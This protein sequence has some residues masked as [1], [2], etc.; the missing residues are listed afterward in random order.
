M[1]RHKPTAAELGKLAK[2]SQSTVSLVLTGKWKGR[3]SKATADRVLTVAQKIGYRPNPAAQSLRLGGSKTILFL[4]PVLSNP[5]FARVYG[6]IAEVAKDNNLTIL[7]YPMQTADDGY[8][9][10]R[11]IMDVDAIIACSLDSQNIQP[12]GNLIPTVFIDCNPQSAQYTVNADIY[13]GTTK[14]IKKLTNSGF[15]IIYHFACIHSKWT[16][17]QRMTA[18][19]N[20]CTDNIELHRLSMIPSVE[21]AYRNAEW[22]L[23]KTTDKIGFFCDNDIIAEGV[24]LAAFSLNKSIPSEVSIIGMDDKP[25]NH[26]SSKG[27]S[28]VKIDAEMLGTIAMQ[29]LLE[30][31]EG[32]TPKSVIIPTQLV[33]RSTTV[34][35]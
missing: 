17:N 21:E 11:V 3:V 6:A 31:M 30:L 32:K 27:L 34:N 13:N 1:F 12:M 25:D 29:N 22:L 10:K 8:P 9:L 15:K 20:S 14:A 18:V 24:Q 16:F 4:I 5:F 23:K 35:Y 28:S 2:V 7:V 26:F 19:D 33:E